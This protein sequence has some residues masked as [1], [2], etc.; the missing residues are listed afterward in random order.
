MNDAPGKSGRGRKLL[1]KIKISLLNEEGKAFMGPGPCR[2]LRHI[3]DSL[4][5]SEAARKMG[6]SYAK[7]HRLVRLLEENTGRKILDTRIGGAERGGASLTPYA[8]SLLC[9][10][11][12][13]VEKVN[14]D[15]EKRFSFLE[16]LILENGTDPG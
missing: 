7:A 8:R 12:E 9:A 3:D 2:L 13:L 1:L 14:E 6:M 4:S 15:S 16:K 10:F 11:E 5:I